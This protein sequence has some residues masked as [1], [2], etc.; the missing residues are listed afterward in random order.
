MVV[1]NRD[2]PPDTCPRCGHAIPTDME[3]GAYRGE[4]SRWDDATEVCTACGED[5]VML[6][7]AVLTG[8]EGTQESREKEAHRVLHPEVGE[9]VWFALN[10]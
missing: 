6:Q 2:L 1:Y 8:A 5:E 4:P 3:P 10:Q 9:L 7:L